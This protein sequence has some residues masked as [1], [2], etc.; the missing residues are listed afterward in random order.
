VRDSERHQQV[1]DFV[2]DNFWG[3]DDSVPLDDMVFNAVE[4]VR[5]AEGT[6][7]HHTAHSR[8]MGNV[9]GLRT[10]P[11]QIRATQLELTVG[12]SCVCSAITEAVEKSMRDPTINVLH[13]IRQHQMTTLVSITC[14][15]FVLVY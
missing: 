11:R 10:K 3:V 7:E 14:L 12:V 9:T 13:I 5:W 2:T 8:L 1:C 4:T 15:I 6:P